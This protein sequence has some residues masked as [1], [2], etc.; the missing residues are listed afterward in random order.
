MAEFGKQRQRG[1]ITLMGALFIIIVLTVMVQALN[2][3]TGSSVVD[4]T[5]QSDAVEALFIAETGVEYASYAYANGTACVD[6]ALNIGSISSGRGSF[7]VTA[8]SAVNSTD[9]LVTV[10]ATASSF[11]TSADP[12]QRVITAEL[13]LESSTVFAVGDN[14]TIIQWNGSAWTASS[15]GITNRDLFGVHCATSNSCWA[16]GESG[17]IRYW[18]GSSWSGQNSNT[19]YD[20][21]SVACTPDDPA[22]C[23]AAGGQSFFIFHWGVIQYWNGSSWSNSETISTLFTDYSFK[24]L[25]CPSTVCYATSANGY[26][27]RYNGG[28]S[29]DVSGTGISMNGIDCWSD[30]DC[31]AVGDN[32][33]T[34]WNINRRNSG[35]W[36]LN[37]YNVGNQA[38]Q[39]LNT[40][41]CI[42]DDDC[43][44]AGN[45]DAARFVFGHWNG[46]NWSDITYN[47]G[48]SRE[49]I[50]GIH[51]AASND[52]WA[53]GN[54]RN[55]NWT[56][57]HYDGIDWTVTGATVPNAV[58][59]HD[60][61]IGGGS[62]GGGVSLLSW[63]EVVN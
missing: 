24:D 49:N 59:L 40:I 33:G 53:V 52:C 9:C 37:S 14:G 35:G 41:S 10:T 23:F 5:T 51:C 62:G 21:H 58:D 55:G 11:G 20:L 48:S 30:I 13:R 27:T 19:S 63:T 1:A 60:V 57:L 56:I 2:R 50:N 7:D 43:W 25:S 45:H 26:I 17:T 31:W 6:L 29:N 36:N 34:K 61:Y 39:P 38:N 46:S 28:W 54:A 16:V 4:T 42:A 22:H 3:M 47:N 18:D 44:A 12:A 32:S 8:S 15:S